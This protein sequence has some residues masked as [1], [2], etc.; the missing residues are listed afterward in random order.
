MPAFDLGGWP[1]NLGK[2]YPVWSDQEQKKVIYRSVLW[3]PKKQLMKYLSLNSSRLT[4]S[5]CRRSFTGEKLISL[6]PKLA[7]CTKRKRKL[8]RTVTISHDAKNISISKWGA[9]EFSLRHTETRKDYKLTK[10]DSRDDRSK[11]H[12]PQ[13]EGGMHPN[14][15]FSVCVQGGGGALFVRRQFAF[16]WDVVRL[17]RGGFST[18]GGT[19]GSMLMATRGEGDRV[20]TSYFWV[21][22]PKSSLRILPGTWPSFHFSTKKSIFYASRMPKT[23]QPFLSSPRSPGDPSSPAK[24]TLYP[25]E[26][27]PASV[28][29]LLLVFL[30]SLWVYLRTRGDWE[31]DLFGPRGKNLKPPFSRGRERVEIF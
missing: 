30:F 28:C 11:H 26:A 24:E 21:A 5:S 19:V 13:N 7:I 8:L 20:A 15:F 18:R 6:F 25:R 14:V 3:N 17:F 29:L 12:L 23:W 27:P 1:W 4:S 16:L 2:K 31:E 22:K 10:I 9:E